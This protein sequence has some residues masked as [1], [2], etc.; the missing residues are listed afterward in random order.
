MTDRPRITHV[1]YDLDG[2]LLDTEPLYRQV[3]TAILARF[4]V[5]LDPDVRSRMMG[6]PTSIASRILVEATGIPLTPEEFAR[7]RETALTIL[8]RDVLPTRGALALTR[9]LR[10]HGIPQAIATSSSV[11]SL[12]D[13][14]VAHDAWFGEFEAIV[15][16]ED[17]AHGKPAPDIFLEAGRR[18]GATPEACLV[19]E[20]AP[21]GVEAALA[22]GMSVIALPEPDHEAMVAGAHIILEHLE[23]F[24]PTEWGL[25]ARG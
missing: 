24:D 19:F 6:R 20:D 12:A 10:A 9:H 23:A 21:L 14:R 7:E 8:F 22:A 2:T 17:V 18:I 13:K 15:T 1:I 16:S 4:G 5:A 25:P 11:R 3:T